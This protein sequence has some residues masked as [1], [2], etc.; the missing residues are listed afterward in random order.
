[1]T[2][3]APGTGRRPAPPMRVEDIGWRRGEATILDA[4]SCRAP[5]GAFT[6]LIGPNGSGK[7][8]LLSMIARWQKPD[9]GTAYLGE[10]PVTAMRRKDLARVL[11]VV[12]QH[13]AT[14]LGL[15]VEQIVELGTIPRGAGGWARPPSGPDE[16]VE[17][18]LRQARVDHLRHRTWQTLSG[19]E[20]QKT[21]LAQALAQQPQ[22]LLLDEPTNH[23][24]AAASLEL[25]SL[26]AGRGL[27][28]VAAMH[29]LQLAAMFCDHLLVLHRG[30]V[31]AEGP[32][33]EVL[34]TDLLAEVYGLDAELVAHP[35]TGR[36]MVVLC[37]T[38]EPSADAADR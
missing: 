36:P 9:T 23:L 7:T 35:R 17:T 31:Y 10:E 5:A 24:D 38:V 29:D 25:L 15:T 28:V 12:E 34:T 4:V 2:A 16:V 26:V 32:P 14:E 19:G 6:G 20:R 27:T 37:G 22:V 33:D 11:A 13:S 30:R 18:A 21:Q 1:M 8:T 3:Q